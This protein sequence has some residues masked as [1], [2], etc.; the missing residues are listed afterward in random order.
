[1][2]DHQGHELPRTLGFR[3]LLLLKLVAII[4]VSLLPPVAGYGRVTLLLWCGAFLLFFVPEAV[5]VLT[6]AR[7]H[8]I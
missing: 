7:R 4:N 3:D 1:M 5:A 8:P 2:R 6:L